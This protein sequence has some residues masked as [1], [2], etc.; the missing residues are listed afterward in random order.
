LLKIVI[1]EDS[2]AT[3]LTKKTKNQ[4]TVFTISIKGNISDP[5]TTRAWVAQ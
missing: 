2:V 1:K 3:L 4:K 5:K